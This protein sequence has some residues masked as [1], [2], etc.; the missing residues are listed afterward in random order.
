MKEKL[1]L[2]GITLQI[3]QWA[4][5]LIFWPITFIWITFK[6]FW[7]EHSKAIT[8]SMIGAIAFS[9]ACWVPYIQQENR[10]SN[11]VIGDGSSGRNGSGDNEYLYMFDSPEKGSYGATINE[12][13]YYAKH[14]E[15]DTGWKKEFDPV[16]EELKLENAMYGWLD[17][18]YE[19]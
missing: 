18:N 9:I 8:Y 10:A 5:I 7:P 19:H 16:P 13:N 14:P 4:L 15:A 3:W 6:Y 1:T 11:Y 17:M 12:R 2:W